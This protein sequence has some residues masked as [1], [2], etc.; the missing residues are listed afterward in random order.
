MK[1]NERFRLPEQEKERRLKELRERL[2]T[3]TSEQPTESTSFFNTKLGVVFIVIVGGLSLAALLIY[4]GQ[5][6]T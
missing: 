1:K 3:A 2:E 5:L 4:V 6:L